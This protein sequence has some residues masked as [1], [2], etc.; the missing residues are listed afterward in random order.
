M[1]EILN[2]PN[3]ENPEKPEAL[4]SQ[5]LETTEQVNNPTE[6]DKQSWF[7]SSVHSAKRT[8]QGAVIA[9]EMLPITNE[10]ARYGALAA[11]LVTTRNPLIGAAV[12][13]GTTLAIEGASA[14][15]AS[16]FITGKTGNR[17]FEW[18]NK[19]VDKYIPEDAKM[20]RVVETGVAMTLGTPVLMAIQ[21]KQNPNRTNVEARK[22]GLLTAAWM[23]GVFAVEGALITKGIGEDGLPAKIGAAAIVVG[24]AVVLPKWVKKQISKTKMEAKL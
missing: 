13:G 6:P 9:A 15:A 11:T 14:I 19:K 24:S 17:V 2:Y 10:G 5:Q 20:S 7:K 23:A 1:T 16:E 22:Q 18:I 8:V 3:D 12:L 21:Q 4:L